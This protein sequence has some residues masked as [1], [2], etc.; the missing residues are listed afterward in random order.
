MWGTAIHEPRAHRVAA[1]TRTPG[2]CLRSCPDDDRASNNR[3]EATSA[4][5]L[6]LPVVTRR[7]Q[8][9]LTEDARMNRYANFQ[10]AWRSASTSSG[11]AAHAGRR[12]VSSIVTRASTTSRESRSTAPACAMLVHGAWSRPPEHSLGRC[13]WVP[14]ARRADQILSCSSTQQPKAIRLTFSD[15]LCRLSSTR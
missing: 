6:K 7:N 15:R 14:S 13:R 12:R 1:A 8:N 9:A 5:R 11:R 3:L 4:A 10:L 2:N